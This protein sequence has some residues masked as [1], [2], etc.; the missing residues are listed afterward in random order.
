MERQPCVYLLARASHSTFYTGVTS[1]LIGRIW[2]HRTEA[3]KGFTARYGIKRLVW[4]EVHKTMESAILREKQIKRWRRQW[5]YDLVNAD[6][7]TW[8]DLAEDFGF[9]PLGLEG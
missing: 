2:Q 4:F 5:K 8:R 9:E 1:D 6:N 7:P 3:T